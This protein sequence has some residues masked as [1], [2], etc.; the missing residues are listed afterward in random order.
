MGT[1]AGSWLPLA[2]RAAACQIRAASR[3][4]ATANGTVYKR[5]TTIP[6]DCTC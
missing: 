4:I 3:T 5:T 6:L 2:G 1:T